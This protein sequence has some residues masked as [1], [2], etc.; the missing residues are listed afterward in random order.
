[1]QFKVQSESGNVP[2][3]TAKRVRNDN[4]HDSFNTST[5]TGFAWKNPTVMQ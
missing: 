5:K 1:M 2:F 3:S 4:A